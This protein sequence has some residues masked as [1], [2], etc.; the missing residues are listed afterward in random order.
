MP[1]GQHVKSHGF[2][3]FSS[4]FARHQS[5]RSG[6]HS[7]GC[8]RTLAH[9]SRI[10]DAHGEFLFVASD[11]VR[12]VR[13]V[14]DRHLQCIRSSD[15]LWLVAPDGY[16]GQSA[17]CEL[18]FAIA[19]EIPIFATRAPTDLTLRQYVRTVDSMHIAISKVKEFLPTA[20]P[21]GFLIDPH[22][23][24]NEA[25]AVLD[26]MGKSLS[27]QRHDPSENIALDVSNF[28][29]ELGG[30]FGLSDRRDRRYGPSA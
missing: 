25:H 30:L 15:F 16:V 6:T 8:A 2:R 4:A 19:H 18:G 21:D 23:S 27:G 10:V 3:Q 12:S 17:S 28:R 29:Q 13:L 11:R 7:T 26:R 9:E 22:S 24:I 20:K 1:G 5:R 14:Q